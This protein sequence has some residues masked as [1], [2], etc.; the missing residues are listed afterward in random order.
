ME[1]FIV[2]M[3][4]E[5]ED[6]E[7]KIKRANNALLKSE[8]IHLDKVQVALLEEQTEYMKKYL[9]VLNNRIAYEKK[10]SWSELM[11]YTILSV[12]VGIAFAYFVTVL[13]VGSVWLMFEEDKRKWEQQ[14]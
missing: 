14:D 9:D 6:L 5:K 8:E 4:R 2:R 11:I 7:G 13:A 10:T 12:I 1:Q 3:A